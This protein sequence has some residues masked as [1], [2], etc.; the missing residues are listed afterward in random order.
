VTLSSTP[1]CAILAVV[2]DG[3]S[4]A[5]G[6]AAAVLTSIAAGRINVMAIAQGSGERNISIV[7]GGAEG[8]RALAA[9][10]RACI[11]GLAAIADDEPAAQ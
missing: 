8:G 2:G 4:R 10:H 11:E 1:D 9:V 6:V 3:M 7:V 5:I